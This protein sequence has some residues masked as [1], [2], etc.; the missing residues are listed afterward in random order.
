MRRADR[1]TIRRS[2]ASPVLSV[3][4]CPALRCPT[5]IRLD[6]TEPHWTTMN[7]NGLH[8][9][10]QDHTGPNRLRR[11]HTGPHW[12]QARRDWTGAWKSPVTTNTANPSQ[13]VT[14]K[15]QS[16]GKLTGWVNLLLAESADYIQG[17]S[18][19]MAITT[20]A[21]LQ[22][23]SRPQQT[24]HLASLVLTD[25][26]PGSTPSTD[27]RQTTHHQPSTSSRCS[28]LPS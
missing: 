20:P 12:R 23:D 14:R 18:Q 1:P 8:R 17:L 28:G 11:D 19:S 2:D 25:E 22:S 24:S 6:Q 3:L 13:P 7:H 21:I 27:I 10:I 26:P 4:S 16:N 15:Q 9:T 5:L